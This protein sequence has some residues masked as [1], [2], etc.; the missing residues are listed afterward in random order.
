MSTEDIKQQVL[1][2]ISTFPTIPIMVS[3]LMG[4]L[5]EKDTSFS[6]IA[7]V[8][9]YDPALTA[10]V[11]K[12]A[13]SSYM[14]FTRKVNSLTEAS[15]RL[16]TKWI[17]KIAVSSLIGSQI[18]RPVAGYDLTAEQL[19]KHSMATALTTE[20][21]CSI[22]KVP[23]KWLIFTAALIHDMG[24][25][26]MGDIISDSF[27]KVQDYADNDRIS[28][29]EAEKKVFGMNH[30][31]I[32]A[33]VAEK[34]DFPEEIVKCIRWHHEPEDAEEITQSIDV[35]HIA[36]ALCLMQGYGIGKEELRYHPNEGSISRLKITSSDLELVSTRVVSSLEELEN[37]LE[38]D[39]NEEE[40]LGPGNKPVGR[41]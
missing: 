26:L 11:L 35:V 27:E 24:K 40:N 32:G 6:R 17:F 1:S 37:M 10:N 14:G 25:I 39:K 7:D 30:A 12:A 23:D 33:L 2:R 29:Q 28:F 13:N 22:V 20:H 3:K 18:R 38:E 21:L 36:D 5:D 15:I 31:E 8:I 19:W 41:W 34:W 16:G 9:K 4:L